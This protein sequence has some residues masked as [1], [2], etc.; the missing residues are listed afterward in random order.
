M[1]HPL[2]TF[3]PRDIVFTIA[4]AGALTFAALALLYPQALI[5]LAFFAQ[6]GCFFVVLIALVWACDKLRDWWASGE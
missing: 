4:V 1:R 5:H 2:L 3:T 6:L